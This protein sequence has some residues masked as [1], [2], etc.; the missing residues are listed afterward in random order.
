MSVI[1][2][3]IVTIT[4]TY[5]QKYTIK[6]ATL[7]PEGSTWL[8]VM[9]EYNQ[10]IKDATNNEVRFKIYPGGIQGDEKDVLRKIRL[11][12]LH[13]AGFTGVGLGEILSEA[14]ILDSPM[15]F[16]SHEEVD[17]ITELLYDEFARKFDKEGYT[18]L[19]WTEVGFVYVFGKDP[20][21]SLEQLKGT[22]MWMWEGDPIAEATFNALNVKPIPLS[23]TDVLTSLQTNLIEAVYTSPLA[24]VSLQWYTRLDYMV[25]APL[26]DA[27]G[28]VLVSNKMFNKLPEEYRK[29]LIEKG[30]E[31]MQKLR[32]LSREDNAE[33]VE[34]MKKNG[35][36]ISQVSDQNLREFRDACA[37]AR[38]NLVGKLYGQQLLD[39]VES[40]LSEFRQDKV[41]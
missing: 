35:I 16:R 32:D 4:S 1:C 3:L 24:C 27:A 41:N 14:R 7:A 2:I 34:L 22:K 38:Q 21:T 10:E 28:A 12:Q 31:N 15:L 36:Q 8:K 33:S 17:Y 19:G 40:A 20:V 6:F 23:I 13:S 37:K 26:A 29:I 9:E 25:D 11:G 30:R 5:S 18:L 39:R